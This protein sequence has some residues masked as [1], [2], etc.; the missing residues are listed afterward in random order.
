MCYNMETSISVY[1]IGMISW[2]LLYI[3]GIKYDKHLA[4]LSLSFIQVLLAEFFMWYDEDCTWG[5]KSYVTNISIFCI[6]ITVYI[7][8]IWCNNILNYNNKVLYGIF[9]SFIIVLVNN[10]NIWI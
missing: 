7:Y 5:I 6:R 1:I 3:T 8:Y 2:T 4:L 9:I 10:Y